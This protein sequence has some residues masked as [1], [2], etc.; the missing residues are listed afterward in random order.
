[1]LSVAFDHLKDAL[2][3]LR[4][5]RPMMD[6]IRKYLDGEHPSPYMPDGASAEYRLLAERA[7]TNVCAMLVETPTQALYVDNF[8]RSEELSLDADVSPEWNHWQRSGLDAGQV[9]LH[10]ECLAY[11]QSFTIT[12][13]SD[14]GEPVTRPLSPFRTVAL[15]EDPAFDQWPLAGVYVK[16]W[17]V[18]KRKGVALVWDEVY[19]YEVEFGVDDEKMRLINE[20][21]HGSSVCPLTP[22]DAYKDLEGTTHGIIA[23]VIPFQNRLNQTVFDLLMAQTYNSFNVRYV[24]GM[25]PPMK[26]VLDPET[27]T[28]VLA[29]DEEGNPIPEKQY[30]NASRIFYAEDKDVKFG[31]LEG[32]D[33]AGFIAAAELAV[34]HLSSVTQTPPHFVLGQIAN[35]SAEALEQAETSLSRK[36]EQFK[37]GF[38]ESWERVFRIA[39]EMLGEPGWDDHNGEV[40]WR[41][42]G[43]KS[44]AQTADA[45]GK[46]AESLD[47]PRRGLWN[48]I[49]NVTRQQITEWNKLREEDD[50]DRQILE[51]AIPSTSA[52]S[53]GFGSS[54]SG[55]SGESAA[56]A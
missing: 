29:L 2:A 13:K 47:V 50:Y 37:A 14:S 25:A 4:R 26:R 12:R 28:Y 42:M 21:P 41:D 5:D 40:V 45:L 20:T 16:R 24:T 32:G 11:G 1:M 55:V 30:L 7:I 36:I 19:E 39:L 51:R 38:S 44:L 10:R 8:R 49:P 34:R 31:S 43:N 54:A 53:T 35:V 9:P 15:Y 23:P 48:Q 33:L 56:A 17:P 27:D 22:F 3:I 6:E 18:E 52:R 46:F